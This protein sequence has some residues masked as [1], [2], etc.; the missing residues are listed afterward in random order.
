[1]LDH[2][3]ASFALRLLARPVGGGGQEEILEK[4][5]SGLMARIKRRCGMGR[6]E[7]AEIQTWEEFKELRAGVCVQKK[8]DALKTAKEWTEHQRTI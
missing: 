2:R 8:K 7:T 5:K 3:Q 1:M 6:G 4:R